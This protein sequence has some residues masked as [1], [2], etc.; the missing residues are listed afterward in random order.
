MTNATLISPVYVDTKHGKVN[1]TSGGRN[2]MLVTL[3]WDTLGHATGTTGYNCR[4]REEIVLASQSVNPTRPFRNV[5]EVDKALDLIRDPDVSDH[6][7]W[8][9]PHVPRGLPANDA[10]YRYTIILKGSKGS[11]DAHD[12]KIVQSGMAS[13][14]RLVSTTCDRLSHILADA[15]TTTLDPTVK[16]WC[17][18]TSS[19]LAGISTQAGLEATR[20]ELHMAKIAKRQAAKAKK[21]THSTNGATP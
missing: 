3:L 19:V 11:L 20:V 1:V 17:T 8:T 14:S 13:T 2:D 7:G 6:Y 18:D 9:V 10:V 15:A 21:P 16:K 5:P 4:T 12:T